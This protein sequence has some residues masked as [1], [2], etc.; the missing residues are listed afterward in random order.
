MVEHWAGNEYCCHYI[1]CIVYPYSS[2]AK[3]FDG[4]GNCSAQGLRLP[5]RGL[6]AHSPARSE[7]L[8]GHTTGGEPAA[9]C[10]AGQL[11]NTPVQLLDG[12]ADAASAGVG[13]LRGMAPV[14]AVRPRGAAGAVLRLQYRRQPDRFSLLWL[15]GGE[16]SG[17]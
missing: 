13:R 10:R 1:R 7:A 17:P 15:P 2:T 12:S 9:V 16:D 6:A 4:P 5:A 8:C 11:G 3:D 14:A